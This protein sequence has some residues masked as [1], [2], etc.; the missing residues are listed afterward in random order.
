[1]WYALIL[2]S[3]TAKKWETYKIATIIEVSIPSDDSEESPLEIVESEQ[4][5][6][7]EPDFTLKIQEIDP[8]FH[9]RSDT[10]KQN[11]EKAFSFLS[12]LGSW[13]E[14]AASDLLS[15]DFIQHNPTMPGDKFGTIKKFGES[16][17]DNS[18]SITLDIKRVYVD[19]NYV[20]VHSNFQIF[21]QVNAAL[22]DIFK[23]STS[24]KIVE[25]WDV[26]QEIPK[27]SLNENTMLYLD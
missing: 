27:T 20:I 2:I 12:M 23:F 1:M 13:D 4:L 10:E 21:G 8:L 6:P 3:D 15:D 17:S 25:H 5:P 24:G 26:M 11:I 19:G 7:K 9:T 16:F 14:E 18:N 22:I